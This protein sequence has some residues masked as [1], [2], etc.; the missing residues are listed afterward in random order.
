MADRIPNSPPDSPLVSPTDAVDRLRVRKGDE[1][2]LS[3]P[4]LSRF[5]DGL[6]VH[7][8]RASNVGDVRGVR[9]EHVYAWVVAPLPDGSRPS[10]ATMHLRRSAARFAFRTLRELG[11]VGH[12]PTVDLVLDKR[13]SGRRTRPL[14]DDEIRHGRAS[15]QRAVGDTRA[16][17]AWA[18]AEA[19]ATVSEIAR[20]NV[21]DVDLA[22]GVV[23]LA[24][25]GRVDRRLAAFTDWGL[26]A[27]KRHLRIVGDT[28]GGLWH[29]QPNRPHSSTRSIISA[30]LTRVLEE[31]G[32]RHDPK[33]KVGSVRAWAGRRIWLE[34]GRIEEAA[35]ALGCR[36]LD[37]A[38][39]IID[40]DWR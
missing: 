10:L 32:L 13:P 17:A 23:H 4:G 31:A 35:S 20:I 21:G 3:G 19:S 37:T 40:F 5:F 9:R 1:F 6:A 38:A 2:D 25:S 33:V 34:S 27:V 39:A 16:S 26:V 7:L 24:G 15:A 14:T 28:V 29:E 12:D 11:L 18:M 22:Q 30:D 36:N 8:E